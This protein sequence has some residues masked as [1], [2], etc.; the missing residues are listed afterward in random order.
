MNEHTSNSLRRN[1]K[2]NLKTQIA[3]DIDSICYGSDKMIFASDEHSRIYWITK[4][5]NYVMQINVL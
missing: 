1:L 3:Q 2:M 5:C 4:E